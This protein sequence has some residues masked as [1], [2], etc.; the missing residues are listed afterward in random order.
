MSTNTTKRKTPR[1]R[2]PKPSS[3]H[4]AARKFAEDYGDVT[5]ALEIMRNAQLSKPQPRYKSG[6]LTYRSM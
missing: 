4:H 5:L 3:V 1:S 2:K 6:R